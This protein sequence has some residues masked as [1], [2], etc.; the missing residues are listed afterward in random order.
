MVTI[1]DVAA[2]N[3]SPSTVSIVLKGN[4][5]VRKISKKT[6]QKVLETARAL[7]YTPNTQAKILRGGSRS[8]AVITL[9]LGYRYPRQYPVPFPERVAVRSAGT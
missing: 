8:S 1:K 4:G 7:G 5:D 6:Q 2:A 3:L 9:F